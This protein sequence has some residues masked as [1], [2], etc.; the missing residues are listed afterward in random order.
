MDDHTPMN[1]A[2]IA[3]I[4]MACRFPDAP[5][6]EAF[7][8]N[9]A[10]GNEAIA[11]FSDA[12]LLAAGVDPA[13]LSDPNYV[14]AGTRLQDYD[15]FDAPFFGFTPREAE[16]L[17]PQ[18]RLLLETAWTALEAA[19]YCGATYRGALGVYAG[20]GTSLYLLNHLYPNHDL[21][22]SAGA[23][24]VFLSNSA[25]FLATRLSYKLNLTGPSMTVQT[26]CSTS[27]V[28]V[29]LAC[30]SL[31]AGECDMALAGGVSLQI[32]QPQGYLYQ[33]GMIFAPDGHCRAFS[34]DAQGTVGSS[35]V[36]VVLLKPWAAAV[37][38][39]DVIHAVIRGSAINNDGSAKVSFMAPSIDGQARVIRE[40]QAVAEVAPET[41]TYVEA[42]GTGTVLGDPIE[43]AAL[44]QAF[45]THQHGS[46]AI[47]S[48]KTNLGHTDAAAGVAGLIKTVLALK[49]G[50]IPS[51][52]HAAQPNPALELATS[53]FY[54]NTTLAPWQSKGTPRRAGVSSFGAGG[55]NAHVV[56]EEAAPRAPSGPARPWQLLLLSARS[57]AALEDVTNQLADH[58]THHADCNLADVAYTLATG[59]QRHAYRR[60]L[61]VQGQ[62]AAS[63]SL[64][65]AATDGCILTGYAEATQ[66]PV[67]FMFPGQ[68]TQA[69]NMGREL[70]VAEPVF[71]EYVDQCAEL[72]L[73]STGFDLREL[74]YPAEEQLADATQRINQT[75]LAQPAIFVVAYALAQ[76]WLAWGVKPQ[77]MI[78]HSIGEYVAATL[79]GVLSLPDALRL[80]A[81]R[82]RLM[83]SLPE[84]AML[85]VALPPAQLTLPDGLAIAAINAPAMCVIS[86]P[87]DAIAAFQHQLTE[88]GVS[89]QRLHISRAAHSSMLEPI[90]ALFAAQFVALQLQPPQ[91]P[92][93]STLT[94]TWITAEAA[95]DPTYWVRH[96]RQPVQF[97][98]G[99]AEL[100][101]EPDL[102]LLEVG[103][104]RT[105]STLARQQPGL[106]AQVV[107]A[108]LPQTHATQ[109]D[110]A[111]LLTA[112]GQIWLAGGAINWAGFYAH[113]RRQRLAL[114]TYPFER[115]RY[116]ID[117]PTGAMAQ[118]HSTQSNTINKQ[119]MSNW[120]YAPSWQRAAA[121][122]AILP[123]P[124]AGSCWLLF[125]GESGLG[126]QLA[127]HLNTAGHAVITV[128]AG[129]T[130]TPQGDAAY[131]L[132]PHQPEQYAA[133]ITELVRRDLAPQHVVHLWR[134]T[135]S[136][137]PPTPPL[138]AS[139]L[140]TGFYSLI[141]LARAL[142]AVTNPL[143]LTVISNHLHCVTG[144]ET[145]IP[146]QATLLGPVKVIPQEYPH[147]RCYS[148]DMDVGA[149]VMAPARVVNQ[150]LAELALHA[151]DAGSTGQKQATAPIVAYRGTYR[152]EPTF[153]PLRL[154]NCDQG[155]LGQQNRM[156]EGGVYLI[157]G[158]LGGIG[159]LLAEDLA[160]FHAKLVLVSRSPFPPRTAWAEWL[161]THAEDDALSVKIG[162][163]QAI[164][165]TGAAVLVLAAD[166]ADEPQMRAVIAQAER[167]F[168]PLHGVIHAAGITHGSHRF[169]QVLSPADCEPQFRAKVYG[170]LV[171]QRILKDK[172]LDFCML[173][174]SL[175]SI[176]GG[177]GFAAYAAANAFLDAFVTAQNQANATQWVSVNWDGWRLLAVNPQTTS[178]LGRS[179]IELALTPAEGLAVF[180]STLNAPQAQPLEQIV[181]STGDIATRIGRW[182][183]PEAPPRTPEATPARIPAPRASQRPYVAPRNQ[184]E[185]DLVTIWQ[186]LLGIGA[187]GIMDN[188]WELGGHS[189]LATQVLARIR[190]TF[191][192]TL[193]MQSIFEEPTVA[194]LA[195]Y[196][197]LTQRIAVGASVL[198][199]PDA[200]ELEEGVL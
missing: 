174:S 60:M 122:H 158:G 113:E 28:A 165:Q 152:W 36:G 185:Q 13:L 197:A 147:I 87:T 62:R 96:L 173:F 5:S 151:A 132:D 200:D 99:I 82:G 166:V 126:E 48:V 155:A 19:G 25:D 146:A 199:G 11:R 182:V 57:E 195:S 53:P 175:A 144:A 130:F 41:I 100:L 129:M 148:I 40:A 181:V 92:Y 105:L 72:L 102:I 184:L 49:H 9:L 194:G 2:A 51:S 59:R 140:S 18:Q 64:H 65:N 109:A 111:A 93:I 127:T 159:L 156:R 190:T 78:G 42:H 150:V 29:H 95:T 76:Q 90:L 31:L 89:C 50:L 1:D 6:P 172:A 176:L 133:L 97:A 47:G 108:S 33:A 70:Y 35:G 83:Q 137:P 179:T 12:E 121:P 120:F 54:V 39:G 32:P 74:L 44:K 26:A 167:S 63:S 123:P 15:R 110:S 141:F 112:L 163:L 8:Q 180:R 107:I 162:R 135:A 37:A 24:Q 56:L 188:F 131:T 75:A 149:E 164:E 21:L 116:W 22:Q 168:G 183:N 160:T 142:G 191:Q 128:R 138:T 34:A 119:P 114:P 101:K 192:I 189:L 125:V 139:D 27:L 30:Q 106:A 80:V 198:V 153:R 77:A 85:T 124:Q 17:D 38:D 71:R 115:Q 178:A 14:Q 52:L 23:Y 136:I 55:T 20:S 86:G 46:C 61:V 161:A 69:V 91:I 68:G 98:T 66:R 177:I 67:V 157:T 88:Q 117:P 154:D 43:I 3:I 145:L 103:P 193:S 7:W 45:Q 4:G 104:G 84:G 73:P 143:H 94:G 170:P 16:L 81:V 169:I 79:A 10:A 58:L 171:L 186:D 196:L 187:I 134:V 118:A